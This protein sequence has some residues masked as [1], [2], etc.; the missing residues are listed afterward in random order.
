MKKITLIALFG[1]ISVVT[2]AQSGLK[3]L[4]ITQDV[5]TKNNDTLKSGIVIVPTYIKIDVKNTVRDSISVT[6]VLRAYKNLASKTANKAPYS[7][8]QIPN[9]VVN[10]LIPKVDFTTGGFEGN[11]INRLQIYYLKIY[12]NN[13]QIKVIP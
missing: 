4:K 3:Y 7:T 6:V 10:I 8:N 9:R 2:T 13:V 5:I 12:P 11:I 1:L